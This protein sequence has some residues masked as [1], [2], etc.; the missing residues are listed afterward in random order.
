MQASSANDLKTPG[1]GALA[2]ALQQPSEVAV[3]VRGDLAAG[4]FVAKSVDARIALP[5]LT[6]QG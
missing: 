1:V 3:S 2:E 5:S 4:R 6:A